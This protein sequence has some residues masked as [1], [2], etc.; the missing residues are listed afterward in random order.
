MSQAVDND[1]Y[2]ASPCVSLCGIESDTGFCRG[3]L[4]TLDE[5]VQWQRASSAERQAILGRLAQ[6]R[7]DLGRQG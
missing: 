7:A 3:C 2:I 4:R 6:R 1:P 5:I